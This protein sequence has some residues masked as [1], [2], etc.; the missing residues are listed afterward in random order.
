MVQQ[1]EA[2]FPGIGNR[3]NL[4]RGNYILRVRTA[5]LNAIRGTVVGREQAE[6]AVYK[7]KVAFYDSLEVKI[8]LLTAFKI[9]CTI[10]F[11]I[12]VIKVIALSFKIGLTIVCS[13][14]TKICVFVF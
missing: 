9:G 12:V 4:S 5:R 1:K 7:E 2:Q 13:T 10:G 11:L 3:L 14:R 6:K 8:I